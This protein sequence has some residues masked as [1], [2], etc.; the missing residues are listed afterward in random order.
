MPTNRHRFAPVAAVASLMC[1]VPSAWADVRAP[2]TPPPPGAACEYAPPPGES[3][4]RGQSPSGGVETTEFY[5]D[6]SYTVSRCRPDGELEVSETITPVRTQG[7]I[8][9]YLTERTQSV[10]AERFV[11]TFFDAGLPDPRAPTIQ[12]RADAETAPGRYHSPGVGR[13]AANGES[14]VFAPGLT[15]PVPPTD[16][17]PERRGSDAQSTLQAANDEPDDSCSN[18]EANFYY[19]N[20]FRVSWPLIAPGYTY[21][22]NVDSMPRGDEYRQEITKGHHTWNYTENG[23]GYSDITNFVADYGGQTLVRASLTSDDFSVVD[24]GSLHGWTSQQDTVASTRIWWYYTSSSAVINETDQRYESP[25]NTSFCSSCP[26]SIAGRDGAWDLHSFGA[27]ESGHSLGL[28]H[29]TTSFYWLTMSP[30]TYVGAVRWRTLG[31]GDVLG[32]RSLYP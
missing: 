30:L 21:Y 32:M 19:G 26:W 25:P 9:L 31:R 3:V 14:V 17:D 29:T 15:P 11:S 8:Q 1:L 20:G 5:S 2:A 24:F 13:A 10:G 16:G 4:V 22:A 23:C 12:R 27:H 18:S 28:R 7:R 6:G